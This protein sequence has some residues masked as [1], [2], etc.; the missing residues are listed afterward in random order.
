MLMLAHFY[1]Y[2]LI[3]IFMGATQAINECKLVLTAIRQP[4]A[5]AHPNTNTL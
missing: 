5:L 2:F 3:M 4:I 1:K